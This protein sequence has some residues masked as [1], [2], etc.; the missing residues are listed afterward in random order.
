ME[1]QTASPAEA[2]NVAD[3][4]VTTAKASSRYVRDFESLFVPIR[5]ELLRSK[6]QTGQLRHCQ[7]RSLCWRYFLNCLPEHYDDWL[8][9]CQIKR[10]QYENLRR[11]NLQ[12]IPESDT[13][14]CGKKLDRNKDTKSDKQQQQQ[15]TNHQSSSPSEDKEAKANDNLETDKKSNNEDGTES[16]TNNAAKC[17]YKNVFRTIER[18]VVRTFPDMEF[19]RQAEMQGILCNILF[20]FASEN[21]HLSYKQGMHELLATLLYVAHT[22]SQNCLIN[23]E[24]DLANE[25]IASLMSLKFLEHDVFHLFSSLMRSIETWY[26]NDEILVVPET[27]M[28]SNQ[29]GTYNELTSRSTQAHS[30][31]SS[32]SNSE[33][34]SYTPPST[35]SS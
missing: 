34:S 4:I 18:D 24:G 29:L 20:N 17:D 5:V 22:D 33:T 16:G 19:F 32:S 27:V 3:K 8:S 26:Q 6:A 30:S 25:T 14:D 21:P 9:T 7:F 1:Q 15:P 13:P 28:V 31:G 35:Q 11:K 2:K 10:Q 23:Y 12:T